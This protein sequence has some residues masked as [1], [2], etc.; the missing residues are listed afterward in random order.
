M[1]CH[2]CDGQMTRA[3]TGA[4]NCSV[5]FRNKIKLLE[6]QLKKKDD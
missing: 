2:E 5:I 4:H 3:E 6:D 1:V